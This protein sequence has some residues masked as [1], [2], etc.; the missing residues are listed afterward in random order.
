MESWRSEMVFLKGFAKGRGFN[1]LLKAI[2]CADVEH[3]TVKRSGGLPYVSHSIRVA[4]ALM[5]LDVVDELTLSVAVLHDVPEDHDCPP[6]KM[7]V[8]YGIPVPIINAVEVLNKKNYKE[9]DTAGYYKAIYEHGI[10]TI[11]PKIADRCHNVSTM[12]GV[13]ST[14][15]IKAY[16]EE[17]EEFVI[18]LCR[19]AVR[20]Y[21]EYAN[22]IYTMRYHIESI[23]A[24]C[25]VLL[26][27][28]EESK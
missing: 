9:G 4:S 17:T 25:K 3:S 19:M 26:A 1:G 13:F 15:K 2:H 27:K 20:R 8:I 28:E 24:A 18:P 6:E 10:A 14:K 12:V 22:A 7:S 5:T 23:L 16:V 21:P 11:L